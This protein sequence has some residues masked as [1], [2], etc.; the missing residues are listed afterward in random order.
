MAKLTP[1]SIIGLRSVPLAAYCSSRRRF[2]QLASLTP[3]VSIVLSC[4]REESTGASIASS[5]PRDGS[6]WSKEIFRPW[7]STHLTFQFVNLRLISDA[8]GRPRLKIVKKGE[9]AYITVLFPPQHLLEESPI[10]AITGPVDAQL[11]GPSQL[12]FE[13][14]QG[15]LLHFHQ[16]DLLNWSNP[17]LKL[18]TIPMSRDYASVAKPTALESYI[19]APSKI[20]LTFPENSEWK[21]SSDPVID[22]T[23]K[24]ELWRAT[25]MAGKEHQAPISLIKNHRNATVAAA[26]TDSFAD[27]SSDEFPSSLTNEQRKQLVLLSHVSERCSEPIDAVLLSLSSL[28]AWLNL[29]GRWPKILARQDLSIQRVDYSARLSRDEKVVVEERA[30][31]FPYGHKVSLVTETKRVIENAVFNGRSLQIAPLRTIRFIKVDEPIRRHPDPAMT[32]RSISITTIRTPPLDYPPPDDIGDRKDRAFWPT[33]G[34][35][36]FEFQFR[37]TD[38]AG[39]PIT[40]AAPAILIK[41]LEPS[42]CGLPGSQP[43]EPIKDVFD[44]AR[45]NYFAESN[46]PRRYR[47]LFSQL[48]AAAR[49]EQYGDTTVEARQVCFDATWIDLAKPDCSEVCEPLPPEIDRAPF[50]PSIYEIECALPAAK[51]FLPSSPESS[52][53]FRP[54]DVDSTGPREIF[55]IATRDATIKIPFHANTARSGLVAAPTPQGNALS[56][57]YGPVGLSIANAFDSKILETLQRDATFDPKSFFDVDAKILGVIPLALIIQSLVSTEKGVVPSLL[58]RYIDFGDKPDLWTQRL[59]WKTKNLQSW[60]QGGKYP[61][62]E[63]KAGS[64]LFIQAAIDTYVGINNRSAAQFNGR[65]ENFFINVVYAE[66][67]F[68]VSFSS[69]SFRA[70]SH[71]KLTFTP[72]ID[73]VEFVGAILSFIQVLKEYLNLGRQGGI[74]IQLLTHGITLSTGPLKLTPVSLGAFSITDMVIEAGVSV[75]FTSDPLSFAF[76]FS[77]REKPFLVTVGAYGGGG[78]FLI[79]IDTDR[80]RRMEAAIEFGAVAAL[81]FGVAS[82]RLYVMG[83]IYYSSRVVSLDDHNQDGKPDIG[84]EVVFIAYVR[85]GGSVTV[86]GCISVSIELYLALVARQLADGSSELSGVARYSATVKIGFFKKGFS[87]TYT[88]KFAGSK[89]TR[90]VPSIPGVEVFEKTAATAEDRHFGYSANDWAAYCNAFRV[91][92]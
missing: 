23:E 69:I 50:E 24:V 13:V 61:I 59:D 88:K 65:L 41:D 19:E 53:W 31:L 47:A 29:E 72:E 58:D 81:S 52:A 9:P 87:I 70:D 46:R 26:W 64:S 77:S 21:L 34:G 74:N 44:A 92:A 51:R 42:D 49:S 28:G 60:P 37:G 33:L 48:V 32:F 16:Q 11:S 66:N 7:D 22:G 40:W 78:F 38:Y 84:T 18:N 67:G 1:K 82:G 57:K 86:F 36:P 80:I 75:P 3:L 30:F 39:N 10:G 43:T 91:A 17:S 14:A 62:F 76:S 55:A 89:S 5:I 73:D 90:S 71:Q 27:D 25:L 20:F 15:S 56:R 45:N 4:G 79:E 35:A 83:G 68:R 63:P 12:V 8:R 6:P 54:L 85:A 2:L